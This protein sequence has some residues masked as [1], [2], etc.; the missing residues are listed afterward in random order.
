MVCRAQAHAWPKALLVLVL[1]GESGWSRV[2]G[3]SGGAGSNTDGTVT[4]TWMDMAYGCPGALL[5]HGDE[6][7]YLQYLPVW[8]R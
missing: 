8:V 6:A 1:A 3:W 4:M 5:N 2:V 7:R